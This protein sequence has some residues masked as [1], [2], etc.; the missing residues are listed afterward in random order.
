MPIS[1]ARLPQRIVDFAQFGNGVLKNL[2]S[3][4]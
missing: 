1:A 2:H 4:K 3:K